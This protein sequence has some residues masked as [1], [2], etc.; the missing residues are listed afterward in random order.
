M[1]PE[2]RFFGVGCES[3]HG[4]GGAHAQAMQKKDLSKGVLLTKLTG[5]GGAALNDACGKCHRTAASV[6]NLDAV[7]K[8]STQRFQPYGLSLSACFKKSADKLTCVTCHSPHADASTDTKGYEKTCLSCHTA[9]QQKACPVNPKEKCVSCHMP[10]RKV[11]P[12]TDFPIAM[13]DHFIRIY[14]DAKPAR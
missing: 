14:R 3:C 1:P 6:E 4:P 13:A 12:G 7:A 9:P 8:A 10:T 11:F 2:P 5:V